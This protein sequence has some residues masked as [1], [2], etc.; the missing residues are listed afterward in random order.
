MPLWIIFFPCKWDNFGRAA[1]L[2]PLYFSIIPVPDRVSVKVFWKSVFGLILPIFSY[3]QKFAISSYVIYIN[4]CVLTL[5]A[6]G[7]WDILLNVLSFHATLIFTI[8]LQILLV[9][10]VSLLYFHYLILQGQ[11]S[12]LRYFIILN[13]I[14]ILFINDSSLLISLLVLFV[15][16]NDVLQF[17]G[18][19][20][21]EIPFWGTL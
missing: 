17:I 20:F 13:L 6:L 14:D 12:V 1:I 18:P 4:K 3:F 9:L 16:A 8:E 5:F 15:R 21:W 11:R 7:K 19:F 10:D 2:K